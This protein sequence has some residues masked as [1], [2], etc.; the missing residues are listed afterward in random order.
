MEVEGLDENAVVISGILGKFPKSDNINDLM[1]NLLNGEDCV[2]EDNTSWKLGHSSKISSR[3]GRISNL[4]KFDNFFFGIS[5]IQAKFLSPEIRMAMEVTFEAII[6]AGINPV[7]LRNKKTNVY[8]ILLGL[9]QTVRASK[10]LQQFPKPIWQLSAFCIRIL[11]G[12]NEL[13]LY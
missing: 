11:G 2:S 8:G 13:K 4:T 9:F 12:L 3:L 6:D 10:M 5:A 7:E 1:A